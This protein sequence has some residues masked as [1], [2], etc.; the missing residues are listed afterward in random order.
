MDYDRKI[1]ENKKSQVVLVQRLN[2][3]ETTKRVFLHESLRLEGEA[4]I[5]KQLKKEEEEKTHEIDAP[6]NSN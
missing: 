1:E 5:L 6:E 2:D 4:R 3:L